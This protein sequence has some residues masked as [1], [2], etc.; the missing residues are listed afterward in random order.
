[1]SSVE[2]DNEWEISENDITL[3]RSIGSGHFGEVQLALLPSDI[4]NESAKK[5]FRRAEYAKNPNLVIVKRQK[6][7]SYFF[8]S[9]SYYSP[10]SVHLFYHC[11]FYIHAPY[12][13]LIRA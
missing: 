4:Q 12:I 5:Y 2:Q 8:I 9:I 7:S 13:L 11:S 1:M 6:G 10:H 3:L